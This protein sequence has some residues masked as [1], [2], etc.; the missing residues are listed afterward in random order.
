MSTAPSPWSAV[1]PG[2]Q[3]AWDATSLK[4]LMTCPRY[5]QYS[6]IDGWRGSSVDTEFGGYFASAVETYKGARID[7]KTKEQATLDAIRRVLTDTWIRD[8]TTTN[9]AHGGKTFGHFWGGEY[10]QQWRCTGVEPFRNAKGNKAKCPWSFKGH[11]FP[12]QGGHVCGTC[13]SPTHTERRWLPTDGY[14]DRYSLLR[15]VAWYCD[16]QPENREDGMWPHAV[17][18]SF[19]LP[20]P[21][22]TMR[23]AME[24]GK[25]QYS[26]GEQYVLAGHMDSLMWL[27][28][29]LFITD[30]KTTGK[31]LNAQYWAQYSPNIQVDVYDYAGSL[32]FPTSNL[33]GVVIEGAQILK[34]GARFGHMPFPHTDARRE[35]FH[36]ELE[37]WLRQAERYAREGYWPMNRS[38]CYLC[39][40]KKVCSKEPGKRDFW[41]KADF[42]KR[43]WN[44]LEER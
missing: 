16:D 5:Y 18:L 32:L 31:S 23:F 38:A 42:T 39:P 40:F 13:G 19:K 37:W 12:G 3:L 22:T 29:E 33:R 34:G 8:E 43:H 26:G 27:G 21:W 30:N 28:D 25:T 1:V 2:L 36:H 35:E 15:L 24:G 7:G 20:L 9:P 11:W 41:L 44:P 14:K 4:A 17:E 10:Q 6:I